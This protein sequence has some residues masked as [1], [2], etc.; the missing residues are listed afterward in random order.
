MFDPEVHLPAAGAAGPGPDAR[1]R[2][3]AGRQARSN[4]PDATESAQETDACSSKGNLGEF[5]WFYWGFG[6]FRW[7]VIVLLVCTS[8]AILRDWGE[9]HLWKR[10]GSKHQ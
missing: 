8:L 6:R 3:A 4:R 2:R 10:L 9:M 7:G 1:Q 5:Y